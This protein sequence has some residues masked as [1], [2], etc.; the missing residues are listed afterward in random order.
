MARILTGFLLAISTWALAFEAPQQ[1]FLVVMVAVSALALR[2]F[3]KI[4][5]A[6][7]FQPMSQAG[8]VAALL[9]L[10]VPN[11][12][13]GY[14]VTLLALVLLGGATLARL[15]F[16]KILATAAITLAGVIYVAGP[17][18]S[19]VLLHAISPHWLFFVL[20]SIAVGDTCALVIG[21][22]FGRY[23]LA[24]VLSPQKTWEGT[25]SSVVG[26]VLAGVLYAS[27]F[28]PDEIGLGTAAALALALNL[29]SQVGDLVESAL[30]R[31]ANLKDS[32]SILPGHGGILDRIDGL[33]FAIPV[34]YG[35]LQ[36]V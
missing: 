24:P 9:W 17:V 4:A 8:Q 26:S 27:A 18:F 29:A 14:F 30:K 13:R 33:L 31:S 7:G 22:V 19:S 23:L 11:L 1:A 6:C 35:Y 28:L 20:V 3:F 36:L 16:E 10:L 21:K 2:E 34:A 5:A 15:P 25:I 12:D 32:G